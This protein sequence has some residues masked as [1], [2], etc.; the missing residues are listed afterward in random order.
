MIWTIFRASLNRG[1]N[2]LLS[3]AQIMRYVTETPQLTSPLRSLSNPVVC[4]F[5]TVS[6]SCDKERHC[7]SNVRKVK[8]PTGVQGTRRPMVAAIGATAF[9]SVRGLVPSKVCFVLCKS[10]LNINRS[11]GHPVEYRGKKLASE[12]SPTT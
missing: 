11:W 6:R 3:V 1:P 10:A 9:V 2:A 7:I 8:H 4:F 5:F 12:M